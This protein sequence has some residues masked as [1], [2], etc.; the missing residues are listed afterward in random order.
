MGQDNL[1][2]N[3][4]KPDS[5]FG[6]TIAILLYGLVAQSRLPVKDKPPVL[7]QPNNRYGPKKEIISEL[8]QN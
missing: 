6:I 3:M 4:S 7:T 5:Y 2:Q 1:Q 8:K